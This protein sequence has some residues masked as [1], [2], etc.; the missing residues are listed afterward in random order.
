MSIHKYIHTCMYREEV[1][2]GERREERKVKMLMI[3][4]SG[5]RICG[6]FALLFLQLF[7]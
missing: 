1:E 7:L 4:E 5:K 3:N 2:A 6:Y